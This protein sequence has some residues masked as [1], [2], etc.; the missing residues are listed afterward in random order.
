M[1]CRMWIRSAARRTDLLLYE[2]RMPPVAALLAHSRPEPPIAAGRAANGQARKGKRRQAND[3]TRKHDKGEFVRGHS[4][5]EELGV[6]HEYAGDAKP[7]CK[8]VHLPAGGRL[9]DDGAIR[10][11]LRHNVEVTGAQEL[12]CA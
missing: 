5:D 7:H 2:P 8:R 12:E 3:D 11:C 6:N 10:T 4:S 1:L 9:Q